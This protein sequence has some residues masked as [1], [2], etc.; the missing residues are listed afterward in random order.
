LF[1]SVTLDAI[2]GPDLR[3]GAARKRKGYSGPELGAT[4]DI[5][6]AAEI[7]YTFA[8]V[9]KTN[10]LGT[11]SLIVKR[12]RIEPGTVIGNDDADFVWP[13]MLHRDVHD[14]AATVLQR[15]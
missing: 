14:A 5:K 6:L 9:K 10:R 13:P 11:S 15:I 2:S 1:V 4:V 8:K 7:A 3:V 12:V